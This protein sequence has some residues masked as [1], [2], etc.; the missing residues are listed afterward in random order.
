MN[1]KK[2]K[3]ERTQKNFIFLYFSLTFENLF[4]SNESQI[5]KLM[6]VEQAHS[7]RNGPK[8]LLQR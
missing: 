5:A 8:D 6:R 7:Q 1:Q 2:I 3:F 4:F